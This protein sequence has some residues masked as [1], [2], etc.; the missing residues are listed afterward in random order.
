MNRIK[1]R[2]DEGEKKKEMKQKKLNKASF[3]GLKR[4]NRDEGSC[5]IYGHP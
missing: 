3:Y 4:L 5:L 1:K 2:L